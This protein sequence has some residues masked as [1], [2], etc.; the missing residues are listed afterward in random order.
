MSSKPKDKPKSP[1]RAWNPGALKTTGQREA[2]DRK[3]P[4]RANPLR[5]SRMK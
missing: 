1:W 2:E 4:F 3:V 5:Y